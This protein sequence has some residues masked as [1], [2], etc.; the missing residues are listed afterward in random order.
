VSA[1]LLDMIEKSTT[2]G[3]D[4]VPPEMASRED[5]TCACTSVTYTHPG[6]TPSLLKWPTEK[7]DA[8]A[9]TFFSYTDTQEGRRPRRP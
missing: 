3:G 7:I 9:H 2:D 1:F 8:P 5:D 6:W 4:A